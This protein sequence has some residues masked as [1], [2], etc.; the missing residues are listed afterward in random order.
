M[1]EQAS[2]ELACP[3]CGSSMV[4]RRRRADGAEFWGCPRYPQC[5]GTRQ[6][7]VI[8][9]VRPKEPGVPIDAVAWDEPAWQKRKAGASAQAR[10]ESRRGRHRASV[11][12]RRPKILAQAI[13]LGI[14][15]LVLATGSLGPNWSFLGWSL[16]AIAVLSA[17]TSLFVLPSHIRA[18]GTGAAGE[19]RTAELLDP[20]SAEGFVILHDRRMPP[21][22]EN[23][24]HL[25]IGRP[26]V[27]VV[28]TK[29]YGGDLRVRRGELYVDGRRRTGVIDQVS[30]QAVGVGEALGGIPVGRLIVVHRASFPLF[31]RQKIDGVPILEPRDLVRFLRKLSMVVEE[32]DVRR[33]A[34]L[35]ARRLPPA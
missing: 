29:N 6:L 23:I 5:R 4:R 15:G 17:L 12:R 18:W 34:E 16:L 20:L 13:A 31:G 7:A 33:L 19:V 8:N 10:Y 24:D 27:F 2:S 32:P 14:V 3:V 28:E 26:G 9:A 25:V 30:R 35:A 22:R 11:R 21:G 1:T